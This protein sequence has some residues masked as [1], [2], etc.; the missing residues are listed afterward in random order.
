MVMTLLSHFM[1]LIFSLSSYYWYMLSNLMSIT[2]LW[3][4]HWDWT[5]KQPVHL[6]VPTRTQFR[7]YPTSMP[8]SALI[9]K[10]CHPVHHCFYRFWFWYKQPLGKVRGF[11]LSLFKH[12]ISLLYLNQIL[13]KLLYKCNPLRV[14]N[15]YFSHIWWSYIIILFSSLDLNETPYPGLPQPTKSSYLFT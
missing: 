1:T 4:F 5:K 7:T 3:S 11:L 14:I 10:K 13:N 6:D 9:K 8:P 12:Y 15:S 2:L